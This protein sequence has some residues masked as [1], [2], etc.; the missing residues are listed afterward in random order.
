MNSLFY[1]SGLSGDFL[2]DW[3]GMNNGR[4]AK[5]KGDQAKLE[6]MRD[7][8]DIDNSTYDVA[9]LFRNGPSAGTIGTVD[10]A[11]Y[12]G[13]PGAFWLGVLFVRGCGVSLGWA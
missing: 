8:G 1:I 9:D 11:E 7:L 4:R 5:S 6:E 13:K 2:H 12:A 3:G 10:S